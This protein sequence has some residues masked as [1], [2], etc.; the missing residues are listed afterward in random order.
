MQLKHCVQSVCRLCAAVWSSLLL[1]SI[2][3]F[4]HAVRFHG[5]TALQVCLWCSRCCWLPCCAAREGGCHG[6]YTRERTSHTWHWYCRPLENPFK[7][8]HSP[9]TRSQRAPRRAHK[10][11][12]YTHEE[13]TH[14]DTR[15]EC[16]S[17][18][19][20]ETAPQIPACLIHQRSHSSW[21]KH[22]WW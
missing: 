5:F 7:H 6:Q 20:T 2:V 14:V 17:H 21:K 22:M 1:Y 3:K 12:K 18:A 8:S 13:K 10:S 11:H 15:T 16:F 9:D 19:H 4:F